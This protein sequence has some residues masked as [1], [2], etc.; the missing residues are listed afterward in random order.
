MCDGLFFDLHIEF[1]QVEHFREWWGY[2]HIVAH[3]MV[4]HAPKKLKESHLV[5]YQRSSGV[6][7]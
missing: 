5:L 1:F 3:I 7:K 2:P 4:T 6:Q